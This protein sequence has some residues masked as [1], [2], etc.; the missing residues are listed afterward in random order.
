[1]ANI[2]DLIR[3]SYEKDATKFEEAFEEIMQE[4]VTSSID[5]IFTEMFE[6][7]NAISMEEAK[8][9]SDDEDEDDSDSDEEDDEDEDED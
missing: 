7:E 5:N 4:K 3:A 8:D 2:T 6:D 9:D 1:M